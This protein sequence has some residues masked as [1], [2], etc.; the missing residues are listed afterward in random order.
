[1]I[2]VPDA[3]SNQNFQQISPVFYEVVQVLLKMK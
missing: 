3:N 2:S 1:M